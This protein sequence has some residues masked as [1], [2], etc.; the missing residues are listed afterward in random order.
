MRA[1]HADRASREKALRDITEASADQLWKIS[2]V[3]SKYP[4]YLDTAIDKLQEIGGYQAISTMSNLILRNSDLGGLAGFDR[5][6]DIYEEAD[7]RVK[8]DVMRSIRERSVFHK[9]SVLS[10]FLQSELPETINRIFKI[11]E[12][13]DEHR[14]GSADLLPFFTEMRDISDQFNKVETP[15]QSRPRLVA[16]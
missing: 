15:E 7:D 5:L 14:L 13:L 2:N 9:D 4:E 6:V 11:V 12:R 16:E 8:G 1:K 10:L 3:V